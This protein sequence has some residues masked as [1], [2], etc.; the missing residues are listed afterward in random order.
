MAPTYTHYCRLT[1]HDSCCAFQ[2]N[3]HSHCL[4][5]LLKYF[6]YLQVISK[7]S[8]LVRDMVQ[9]RKQ[10]TNLVLIPLEQSGAATNQLGS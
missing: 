4:R 1:H 6:K 8:G 3:H 10:A 5:S 7:Y 9:V 2:G